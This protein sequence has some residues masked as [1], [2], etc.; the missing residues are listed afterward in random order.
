[1]LYILVC[2]AQGYDEV[3]F[4][5]RKP[6][7]KI[8]QAYYYNRAPFWYGTDANNAKAQTCIQKEGDTLFYYLGS[9]D[10]FS[11]ATAKPKLDTLDVANKNIALCPMYLGARDTPGYYFVG[12]FIYYN[13]NDTIWQKFMSRQGYWDITAFCTYDTL[14]T[15]NKRPR[16]E[17]RYT[18]LDIRHREAYMLD[19]N[20]MLKVGDTTYACI[21]VL[22]SY[23]SKQDQVKGKWYAG[24]GGWGYSRT[25]YYL[26]K[27]DLLPMRIEHADRVKNCDRMHFIALVRGLSN[28]TKPLNK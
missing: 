20:T 22:V 5:V 28:Y 1:M 27:S 7:P 3:V 6:K 2:P 9:E 25:Y 21:K 8:V 11:K 12:L 26:R 14:V 19:S 23:Y 13:T 15:G 16:K 4:E 18:E 10:V 17:D 24:G